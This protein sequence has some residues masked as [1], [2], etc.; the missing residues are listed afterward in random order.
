MPL[1][2]C[3]CVAGLPTQQQL[4]N[5]YC[6]LLQIIAGQGGGEITLSQISDLDDTWVSPLQSAFSNLNVTASQIS[7][8][9]PSAV[10][11][12]TALPAGSPS[13]SV[14]MMNDVNAASVID[15]TPAAQGLIMNLPAGD[16]SGSFVVV[17]DAG[18]ASVN[19]AVFSGTG[20]TSVD[21]SMGLVTGGT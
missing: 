5:I 16:A 9:T 3:Q 8:A 19:T 14:V 10:G 2:T 4:A 13:G 21:V 12:L 1:P 20:L 15:A 11:L 17:D 7:D 6:A 18:G